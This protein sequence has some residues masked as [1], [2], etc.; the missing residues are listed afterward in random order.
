MGVP[1]KMPEVGAGNMKNGIHR[2]KGG[3][4]AFNRGVQ[5]HRYK[6]N[7]IMTDKLKSPFP[8]PGGKSDQAGAIWARL[9]D[10]PNVVEPFA[11]SAALTL[12]R[13]HDLAGKTETLNDLDGMLINALRSITFCPEETAEWCDWPV[14][15]ADLTSRHLYLKAAREELTSRLFADPFYCDPLLGA[16]WLWGI[17]SWIGDGWCVAD[18]PWINVG[19]RLV[20]RR[21]VGADVEGVGKKMPKIGGLEGT[22]T[23]Q[24]GIQVYRA[25]VPKKM[26]EI[27]KSPNGLIGF[28]RKGVQAYRHH[29]GVP[30]QMPGVGRGQN[31][32]GGSF[33][34]GVRRYDEP[35]A[36]SQYFARLS[37]RLRR[38][39]FLCGD[40]RRAVKD[41]V[42]VNHGVTG[43]FLDP[44]YP[45]NEHG[46]TYHQG[47]TQE[48]QPHIWYQAAA[49]AISHGDD[50][51]LRICIAG[52]WSEATDS[53]FPAS[54]ER[55]RWEA[56]GGYANQK[57][58]GRG[59]E[60]AKRECL[61]FSPTCLK[62]GDEA[63]QA[64][65]RPITVRDSDYTGTMFEEV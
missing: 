19:G 27:G 8:W 10:C 53:L 60:N 23:Q 55:V 58:D 57:K 26:P 35:S 64:F 36:L 43:L 61:W 17:A 47:E 62:P 3:G 37:D 59:R 34:S 15:E 21:T 51:R 7:Y 38:V 32:Q 50:P 13:P 2:D 31:T 9:G 46:M 18:G 41:S 24:K 16:F 1:K 12:A 63:R 11:G 40:W 65:S 54:W 39:R 22:H 42:T 33:D 6:E 14:S 45:S 20:D 4:Y 25:S 48:G 44:E 52:Y 28:N 49:W 30:K 56:R 5:Y 29:E